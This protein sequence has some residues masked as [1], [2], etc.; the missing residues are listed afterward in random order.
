[1]S[2]VGRKLFEGFCLTIRTKTNQNR[3]FSSKN[4]SNFSLFDQHKKHVVF[5][6]FVISLEKNV[7]Q[8]AVFFREKALFKGKLISKELCN[9][10]IIKHTQNGQKLIFLYIFS[11]KVVNKVIKLMTIFSGA[12]FGDP[13][14]RRC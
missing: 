7:N 12:K 10:M 5:D 9:V 8:L 3:Q 14:R 13:S 4:T 6:I 1:M 11:Q 2:K